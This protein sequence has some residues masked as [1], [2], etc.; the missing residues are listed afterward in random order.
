M[1]RPG[2]LKWYPKVQW[3]LPL[4][5]RFHAFSTSPKST[6]AFRDRLVN[7]GYRAVFT[8]LKT[9]RRLRWSNSH[10]PDRMRDSR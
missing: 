3:H 9:G 4:R 7:Y 5:Q 1:R 8:A 6:M 10:W 2:C